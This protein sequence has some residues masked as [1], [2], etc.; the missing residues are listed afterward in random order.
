MGQ[1]RTDHAQSYMSGKVPACQIAVLEG[2]VTLLH[3]TNLDH[4]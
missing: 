4:E 2:L 1:G 3:V